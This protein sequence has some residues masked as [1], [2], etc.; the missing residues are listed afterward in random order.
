MYTDCSYS[1][2]QDTI[3]VNNSS[4]TIRTVCAVYGYQYLMGLEGLR[5]ARTRVRRPTFSRANLQIQ[6]WI[7]LN[8]SYKLMCYMGTYLEYTAN[9]H[10]RL[11]WQ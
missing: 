4:K 8:S 1:A 5:A 11:F 6:E 9:G 2:R 3:S 7:T 10:G